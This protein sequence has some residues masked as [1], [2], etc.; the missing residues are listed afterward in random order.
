MALA[1]S[2]EIVDDGDVAVI[3]RGKKLGLALE[4]GDA[5]GLTRER[6]GE[7]LDG[8]VTFQLRVVGAIDFPHSPGANQ[9]DDLEGTKPRA[10]R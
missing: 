3:Q 6:L 8:D 7:N 5:L 9:G 2:L 10:W 1:A 4:S